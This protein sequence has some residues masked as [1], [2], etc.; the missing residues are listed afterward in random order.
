MSDTQI[1]SYAQSKEGIPHVL[2]ARTKRFF[3]SD[4]VFITSSVSTSGGR[5]SFLINSVLFFFITGR[6]QIVPG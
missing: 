2:S 6:V 1:Q 5:I 3:V 4:R